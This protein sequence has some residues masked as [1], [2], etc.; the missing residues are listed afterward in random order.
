M[1]KK[2]EKINSP[3]LPSDGIAS[4]LAAVVCVIIGVAIGYI[5]LL[6]ID[7]EKAWSDGLVRII[8]GGFYMKPI[9]VG[10]EIASAAPLIMPGLSVALAFKTG[11][12]NIGFPGP[13]TVGAFGAL[14]SSTALKLPRWDCLIGP[15]AFRAD[16]GSIP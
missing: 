2:K 14:F 16:C 5:I 4:L 7:S 1:K 10:R 6:S 12:F 3:L 8:K 15:P 11:I 13:Y 9:G